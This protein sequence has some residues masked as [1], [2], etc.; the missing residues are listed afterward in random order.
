MY[1]GLGGEVKVLNGQTQLNLERWF[2]Y[3]DP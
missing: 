1:V 3:L 2:R